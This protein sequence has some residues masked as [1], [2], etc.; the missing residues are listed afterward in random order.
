MCLSGI[1]YGNSIRPVVSSLG[2][3]QKILFKQP[4]IKYRFQIRKLHYTLQP[5]FGIQDGN[6][7]RPAVSSW[8]IQKQFF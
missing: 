1:Q 6:S 2:N 7:L 5:N 3:F 8:L 4:Q